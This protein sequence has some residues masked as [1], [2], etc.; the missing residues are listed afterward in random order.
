MHKHIKAVQ[1]H[2]HNTVCLKGLLV[3]IFL[4]NSSVQ[5][6]DEAY[7][8]H[9]EGSTGGMAR[10]SLSTHNTKIKTKDILNIVTKLWMHCLLL[11]KGKRV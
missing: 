8:L 5:R 3:V 7:C 9:E 6:D 2:I 1:E 4:H 10:Q 11:K